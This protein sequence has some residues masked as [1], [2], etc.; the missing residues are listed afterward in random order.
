MVE[1]LLAVYNGEDVLKEQIDSILNQ[2]YLDW[3]LIIYDD[4]STDSSSLIISSYIEKYKE[5]IKYIKSVKNSKS[6]KEA[7]SKLINY[8]TGEYV[9]FC[10]HDD[11]WEKDKIKISMQAMKKFEKRHDIPILI[12]TDLFVVDEKLNLIDSSFF[13]RQSFKLKEKSFKKLLVQNNITGCSVLVNRE[14]LKICN[15]IPKEAVMHDWWLG[16]V[17]ACFGEIHFLKDKTVFYRQ[18][19]KNCVGAKK[20]KSLKYILN[21]ILNR[22]DLE[23]NK[24]DSYRQAEIFLKKYRN[25]ISKKNIKILESY[26]KLKEYKKLKKI[27]FLLYGGFLKDGLTRKIGQ[28][29]I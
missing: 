2:S 28:F 29:F 22:K 17:A 10:D 27:F 14:L 3:R 6:A 1:I 19:K 8:S 4:G 25:I 5:K 18:H 7:F 24:A 9:F 16:L 15:E 20:I 11:V 26:I 12:H 21:R 13:K 23:K